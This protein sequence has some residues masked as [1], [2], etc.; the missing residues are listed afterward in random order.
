MQYKIIILAFFLSA[1]TF[2]EVFFQT[3]D[4]APSSDSAFSIEGK[5]QMAVYQAFRLKNPEIYPQSYPMGLKFEGAAGEARHRAR[6]HR[7]GGGVAAQD[8]R[9][10]PCRIRRCARVPHARAPRELLPRFGD[11]QVC[12]EGCRDGGR[13]GP[14]DRMEDRFG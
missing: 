12:G 2:G 10:D 5:A 9:R 4:F 11:A 13:D 14:D 1:S 3:T 7:D 8:A 6:R